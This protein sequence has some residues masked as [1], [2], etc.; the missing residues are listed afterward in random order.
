MIK[1][2]M[3]QLESVQTAVNSELKSKLKPVKSYCKVPGKGIF[4]TGV[5]ITASRSLAPL[6]FLGGGRGRAFGN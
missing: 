5:N 3:E 4:T 1:S 2:K 6:D